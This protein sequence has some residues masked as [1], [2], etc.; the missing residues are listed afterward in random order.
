MASVKDI[1]A[2]IDQISSDL[3][4]TDRV[5]TIDALRRALNK[6]QTPFERA[7]EMVLPQPLVLAACQILA[8][9]GLWEAWNSAGGGEKS[10]DDL[11]K[12][13]KK[14]C[15]PNLLRRQFRLL[16][17]R[18]IIEE[19]GED[20]FKPTPF[21][22]SLAERN[23]ALAIQS[24]FH[25]FASSAL[26]GPEFLAKTIYREA[27]DASYSIY[28]DMPQNPDRLTFFGRCGSKLE[29]QE[30]FIGL[31]SNITLW[32]QDWTDVYDTKLLFDDRV[33]NSEG[34]ILVD[35]GGNVGVDLSRFLEKHPDVPM[36]SLILQDQLDVIGLAKPKIDPKIT[37]MVY[38]FFTPQPI[39]GSRV[40][41]MHS[42]LHD[43]PDDLA[44]KILKN[45]KPA[46]KKGYSKLLIFDVVVPPVGASVI[47]A[48]HDLCLMSLLSAAERTEAAWKALLSQAGF[49]VV[50][51]WKDARGTETL[52]EAELAD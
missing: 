18:N 49:K 26:H 9:L 32:K 43:W 38:D 3:K 37:T 40:Y 50:G 35:I 28:M 13:C 17:V 20:L 34:P 51:M 33:A 2:S 5:Q 46:L 19:T 44:F 22:L 14:E 4:D 36:G 25:H 1:L 42:I 41:F 39:T 48:A 52:M 12:L 30:S 8:D 15:E 29:Y 21:S 24:G 16:V 31:M 27:K 23:I 11:V 7:W 45:L 10:L 47:Q 6:L